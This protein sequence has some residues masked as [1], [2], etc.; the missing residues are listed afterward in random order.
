MT[1]KHKIPERWRDVPGYEGKYQASTWGEVRRKS[2]S[3]W[4]LLK[5]YTK[6]KTKNKRRVS[7][8]LSDGRGGKY[9]RS[10]LGIVA[11]TWCP[12]P[13][14][15]VPVHRNGVYTENGVENIRFIPRSQLAEEYA[16]TVKRRAVVKVDRDGNILALYRS[17]QA[18]AD[19]NYMSR[20]TMWNHLNGKVKKPYT[21]DGICYKYDDEMDY[22]EGGK[23]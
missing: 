19:A 18:A 13:P 23:P 10:V 20:S 5:G 7:V 21:T 17:A 3:G 12:P 22:G 1:V 8:W 9:E 15:Y 4:K 14:G 6:P 16:V 2:G 11:A